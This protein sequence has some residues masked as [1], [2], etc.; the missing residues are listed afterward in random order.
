M[1]QTPSMSFLWENNFN[2]A[3]TVIR[4][5]IVK[6]WRWPYNSQIPYYSQYFSL[7]PSTTI[8]AM[9]KKLTRGV[10]ARTCAHVPI[11]SALIL[12]SGLDINGYVLHYF[13]GTTHSYK[14]TSC[15]LTASHC[16]QVSFLQSCYMKR[17]TKIF[18]KREGVYSLLWYIVHGSFLSQTCT[19]T[20]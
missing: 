3:N 11:P 8:Q 12:A 1:L 6:L 4:Q 19:L 15:I 9:K 7:L 17:F 16:S 10:C 18:M 14:Y 13:E 20:S 2:S 5:I